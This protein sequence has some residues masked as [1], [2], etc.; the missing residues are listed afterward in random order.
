[1]TAR[2]PVPYD[3]FV[4]LARADPAVIGLVLKGSRAQVVLDRT[5]G[6]IARV[7]SAARQAGR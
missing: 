1:M 6:G 5:A 3:A 4:R 7:G 2:H